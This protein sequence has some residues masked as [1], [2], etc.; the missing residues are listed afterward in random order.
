[1]NNETTSSDDMQRLA[2]AALWCV[3]LKEQDVSSSAEFEAWLASDVRNAAAW[4]RVE[5]AW[6]GLDEVAALPEMIEARRSALNHVQTHHRLSSGFGTMTRKAKVIAGVTAAVVL[7]VL[8]GL[9]TFVWSATTYETALGERRK[10]TLEDGSNLSLDSGTRVR[11]HYT[12]KERTLTLLQGQARFDV[13]HEAKRKFSVRTGLQEVVAT[14]TAFNIYTSGAETRITLLN[15]K[16]LVFSEGAGEARSDQGVPELHAGQQYVARAARP[17]VIRDVNL[18]AVT[19]WEFGQ[20]I[21]DNERLDAV[22]ARVS[23]YT[24]VRV[25]T[26][27][28]AT[29]ALRMSGVFKVGDL[30]SFID[31]VTHYLP[32]RAVHTSNGE[33]HLLQN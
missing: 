7:V 32:V 27:D 5:G 14:G 3:R 2:E 4:Q 6:N 17:P 25:K 15:G 28:Q 13:A 24:D 18:G 30:N 19:A 1:M 8:A 22:V 31:A 10:L 20:L 16:A 21:F 26:E 9:F 23:R 33:I 12:S 29:A 11:V